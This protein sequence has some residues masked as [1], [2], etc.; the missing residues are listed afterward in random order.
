MKISVVIPAFNEEKLLGATLESVRLAMTSF[1]DAG[2]ESELIVCDNN[3]TDRTA[4]IAR[5]AGAL[6]VFESVNQIG[7]ARNRGAAAASGDW[8][9]F[10]DADS[11]PSRGLFADV[12]AAV[13]SGK[14]LYGGSTIRL[15]GWHPMAFLLNGIWN[16]ISRIKK[17]AA[18]S[19]IICEAAAF[20]Q[21]GGFDHEL[22]AGEELKLSKALKALAQA[23]GRR[24]VILRRHPLV[25][26][27]RKLHLYSFREYMG[28]IARTVW[29]GGSTLKKREECRIWY[30]GR[31]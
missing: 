22:F 7:R 14:Y 3:S 16:W 10:V 12:V 19:F 30:D 13:A 28:F 27:S 2:W 8:L 25:T 11:R 31:R 24:G 17:F 15:E 18:G 23:G 20:R 26:S 4:E 6:V 5:A 29:R 9:L 1:Q 21:V